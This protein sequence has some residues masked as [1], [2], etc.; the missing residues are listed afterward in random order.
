MRKRCRTT[1]TRIREG[2]VYAYDQDGSIIYMEDLVMENALGRKLE[3]HEEV[4]HINGNPLDNRRS[5]LEIVTVVKV[6]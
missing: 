1:D 4:R 3:S 2:H 5:N 6:Q